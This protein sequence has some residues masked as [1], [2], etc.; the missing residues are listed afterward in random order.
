MASFSPSGMPANKPEKISSLETA[1]NHLPRSSIILR[2]KQFLNLG[3]SSISPI[4]SL[5][6]NLTVL[7]ELEEDTAQQNRKSEV[8]NQENQR[9]S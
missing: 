9:K 3:P 2:K 8:T 5:K 7:E 6:D 4:N 1:A